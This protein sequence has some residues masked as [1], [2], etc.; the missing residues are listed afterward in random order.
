MTFKPFTALCLEAVSSRFDLYTRMTCLKPFGSETQVIQGNDQSA[1][2]DHT[3]ETARPIKWTAYTSWCLRSRSHRENPSAQAVLVTKMFARLVVR[4]GEKKHS[5]LACKAAWKQVFSWIKNL[6]LPH[7]IAHH[8]ITMSGH[9]NE[10][11]RERSSAP[12]IHRLRRRLM[13]AMLTYPTSNGRNFVSSKWIH[14][15]SL[16]VSRSLYFLSNHWENKTMSLTSSANLPPLWYLQD[17]KTLT[18]FSEK[19]PLGCLFLCHKKKPSNTTCKL[20]WR[21]VM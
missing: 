3:F 10:K 1:L 18:L 4:A 8:R 16:R 21:R 7:V 17:W 20:S 9:A 14:K 2:T 11:C 6:V 15:K 12:L 5:L 13:S 19:K